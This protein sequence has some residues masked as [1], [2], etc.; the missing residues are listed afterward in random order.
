MSDVPRVQI[1][2][3]SD[4]DEGQ[5]IDN[6]LLKRLKGVPKTHVYRLLRTGQVRINKGRA[7]PQRKLVAGDQVRVPPVRVAA[8]DAP[9]R[10]PDE[11]LRRIEARIVH[12]D[13]HILALDKPAGLAVHGGSGVGFGAIEILRALRPDARS[14]ELVHRLDRDT[15]GLLLVAKR[16]SALRALHAALREGKVGKRYLALLGGAWRGGQRRVDAPL[17]EHRPEGGERVT[18]VGP[19]GRG[20]VS[21]FIPERRFRDCVLAAVDIETGRMH[22]IRVHAAHIGH[23]VLGDAKYGDRLANRAA[24]ALGLNRMF[25][26]AA[27]LSF[28]PP[29]D[30]SARTLEAPLDAELEAVLAALPSDPHQS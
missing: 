26:H 22:Q 10:A 28:V 11:L 3:V 7:G 14:L 20:A 24:K 12:E 27:R 5:R 30:G 13:D 2:T 29:G 21:T 16:R 18:R 25:L 19:K 4:E 9:R 23:P 8:P 1:V 6:W 15:S 17:E